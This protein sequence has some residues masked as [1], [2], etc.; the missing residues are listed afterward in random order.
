MKK[1]FF[2]LMLL[3]STNIFAYSYPET[4]QELL[5]QFNQ[6]SKKI[7]IITNEPVVKEIGIRIIP[8]HIGKIR[9]VQKDYVLFDDENNGLIIIII[10]NIVTFSV[11]E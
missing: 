9:L 7:E 6:E 1:I 5:Q 10:S 8:R 4:V 11:M 2:I 3:L